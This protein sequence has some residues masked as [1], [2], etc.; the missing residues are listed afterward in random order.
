[1]LN[2]HPNE[3]RSDIEQTGSLVVWG[4]KK[5]DKQNK[6]SC[7]QRTM[8][9]ITRNDMCIIYYIESPTWWGAWVFFFSLINKAWMRIFR[10]AVDII[11]YVGVEQYNKSIHHPISARLNVNRLVNVWTDVAHCLESWLQSSKIKLYP[12]EDRNGICNVQ[13]SHGNS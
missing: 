13:N 2:F 7:E 11:E 10:I 9:T 4:V 6:T 8:I 12:I 5:Y 1:M 3:R